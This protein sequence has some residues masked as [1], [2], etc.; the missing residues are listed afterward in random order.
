MRTLVTLLTLVILLVG[1][2]PALLAQEAEEESIAPPAEEVDTY[3]Y[4][5][6]GRRDPFLS[7]VKGKVGIT[8]SDC[9]ENTIGCLMI[10]EI[11]IQGIW[12]IKGEWLAEV[13]GKDGSVY[14]IKEGDSLR[15]GEVLSV[16]DK[17]VI[18]RQ[19]VNDP[20][21]IKPFREVVRSLFEEKSQGR[22]K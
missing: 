4:D 15:D 13:Q 9:E 19:K 16:D 11:D 8:H 10:E 21:R 3:S 5:P 14:W 17:T 12:Q 2:T 6:G 18:F 20:T 22:S 1:L 7:L